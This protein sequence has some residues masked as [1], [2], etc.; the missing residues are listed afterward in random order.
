ML[1]ADV[2]GGQ[3]CEKQLICFRGDAT[4]SGTKGVK[5]KGRQSDF[6]RALLR[7]NSP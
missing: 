7:A 6:E 1:E 3:G 4:A 5:K 2:C